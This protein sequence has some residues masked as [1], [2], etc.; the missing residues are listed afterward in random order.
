VIEFVLDGVGRSF[1]DDGSSLLDVLRE[2]FG[3]RSV[4]DGCAPQGQCGCCTVWVDGAPRVSCVTPAKR[5]AGRSVTTLDGLDPGRRARW[6]AA[7]TAAGASQCG[8]CT[9]GIVMRLAALEARPAAGEAAVRTALAAHLCRCTGWTSI[10]E[11][12]TGLLAGA[13]PPAVA[14]DPLASAWRA[15]I[16][17]GAAQSSGPE[18]VLGDGRF[19]DDTAPPTA[20]IA[21]PDGAGGYALAP[22][23][24]AA[25]V[26][27]G[28]IQGR[29][30]TLSLRHPLAVPEGPWA[31][32]LR[33]T[34]LEPAYLE[35]DASWCRP[36][37]RPASPLANGGAFGAKRTSPVRRDAETLAGR[38]GGAVRVL[39][40]REEVVRRGPKRPPVAAGITADGRGVMAA[41]RT[42]GSPPLVGFAERVAVA[43]PGLVVREV[44]VAGPPTSVDLRGAGWVEAAVLRAALGALGSTGPGWWADVTHPGG[45]RARAAVAEDGSVSLEVWAGEVL[46]EVTLRSYCLGAVHQ[47]LGWVFHEGLAV[48]EVGEVQDLT[49]RSF[50]VL[51]ARETPPVHL[52]VHQEDR[53]PVAAGDATVA[54]VAAAAWVAEG[55][56]ECWP[57]RRARAEG[58]EP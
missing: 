43:C 16:E 58:A 25:R 27:A 34:W 8:F 50:G 10:V 47:A 35:P 21:L 49:I 1:E 19:A 33:T 3:C 40:P 51:G 18:V 53:W 39:W 23:L 11:A 45:G 9:P 28:K 46:D 30:S 48:D 7:M 32:T 12:A 4:K 31:L 14:R 26:A 42:P 41:A 56:P 6:A 17:G 22:S 57:T 29:R 20:W 55:L 52:T 24:G 15:E 2:Q 54:A 5:V 13:E 37:G 44:V 38:H 36:G